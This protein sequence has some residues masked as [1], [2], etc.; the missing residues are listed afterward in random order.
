MGGAA[1]AGQQGRL[2]EAGDSEG[3]GDEDDAEGGVGADEEVLGLEIG[4]SQGL[5]K[6][7]HGGGGGKWGERGGGNE[8][9]RFDIH[10]VICLMDP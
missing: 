6:E 5:G 8:G 2:K 7:E 4:I 9:S 1:D 3:R 10:L